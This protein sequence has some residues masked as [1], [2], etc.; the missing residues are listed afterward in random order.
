MPFPRKSSATSRHTPTLRVDAREFWASISLENFR[1]PY[2]A[3]SIPEFCQRF[4]AHLALYLV[5]RLSLHPARGKP[6]RL[7]SLA[8]ESPH[9]L[10]RERHLA[11]AH[12]KFAI[13]GAIHGALFILVN[14]FALVPRP[15]L[16]LPKWGDWLVNG[17]K[18][19]VTFNIVCFA[20]IFFRANSM[21][22]ALTIIQKNRRRAF[23][24]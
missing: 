1:Q 9:C 13:W 20:W 24:G 16:V 12:W 11:W 5:P 19:F 14:A 2:L 10:S 8:G 18:I 22:D 7:A 6:H 4:S 3:K 17:F 21:G 15:K 23:F